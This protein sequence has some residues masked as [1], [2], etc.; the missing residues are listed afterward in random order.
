MSLQV[1]LA[2][3][4]M[5]LELMNSFPPE[6]Q[7]LAAQMGSYVNKWILL[8]P[9]VCVF[10]PDRGQVRAESREYETSGRNHPHC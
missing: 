10:V 5:L 6:D 3:T 1:R 9:L 2:A 4:R 7:K 8:G